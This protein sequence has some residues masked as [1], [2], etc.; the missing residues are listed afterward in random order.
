MSVVHQICVA[1]LTALSSSTEH[2]RLNA[3]TNLIIFLFLPVPFNIMKY[4]LWNIARYAIL[5]PTD[6][7]FYGP[8]ESQ[9]T[10]IL[11]VNQLFEY[12]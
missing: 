7:Y 9:E 8:E 2:F 12:L 6:V 3:D 5:Q 4:Q 11:Q 10:F 1:F